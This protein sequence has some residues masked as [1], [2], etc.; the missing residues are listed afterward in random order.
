MVNVRERGRV[1]VLD[2]KS[3]RKTTGRGKIRNLDKRERN[4]IR[5]DQSVTR[6]FE[7]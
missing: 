2:R 3:L 1:K 7:H 4:R 5:M 6:W